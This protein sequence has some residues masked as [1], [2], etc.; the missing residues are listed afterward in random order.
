M[1]VSK[2]QQKLSCYK[3]SDFYTKSCKMEDIEGALGQLSM[4]N[5]ACNEA[6]FRQQIATF[7]KYSKKSF[8]ET[9]ITLKNAKAKTKARVE[10][11]I[12]KIDMMQKEIPILQM[13]TK[14]LQEAMVYEKSREKAR[15]EALKQKIKTQRELEKSLAKQTQTLL[16]ESAAELGLGEFGQ[17]HVSAYFIYFTLN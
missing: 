17:K 13:K 2:S 15:K 9:M 7:F 1:T 4:K 14:V 10:D 11:R 6:E 12:S 3:K 5:S 8:P 16:A